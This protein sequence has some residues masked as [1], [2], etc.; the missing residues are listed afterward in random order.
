M[1]VE[2]VVRAQEGDREAFTELATAL[3]G[4]LHRVAQNMLSDIHLAEDATQQAVLEMWRNLP[5]LREPERFEAWSY[6]ILVNACKVEGRK[7]KRWLPILSPSPE[8]DPSAEQGFSAIVYR[9]Q[10]ERGLRRLPVQQ[11]EVVVLHH[12]LHLP[13]R[14]VAEM[15]DIKEGT[16]H[17]RLYR[18]M[19]S[20]RAALEADARLPGSDAA[21]EEGAR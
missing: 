4:R 8:S 20:L 1:N 2:L 11:R 7:S 15:L 19:A 12:Y 9:D 16:A 6:R 10:L 3:Y 14:E 13:L 17:S 21:S 5:R 18:A